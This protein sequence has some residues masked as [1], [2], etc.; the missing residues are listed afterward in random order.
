MDTQNDS[1]FE[2]LLQFFRVRVEL[3]E[4]FGQSQMDGSV[5]SVDRHEAVEAAIQASAYGV[6]GQ[7]DGGG[8]I[9]PSIVLMMDD[10]WDGT[11]VDLLT[12]QNHFFDRSCLDLFRGD[13]A[14]DS[15]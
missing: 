5:V 8:Q 13:E 4:V 10:L 6:P 1:H 2:R 3:P 9:G 11:Q 12:L 14:L 15:F 7:S